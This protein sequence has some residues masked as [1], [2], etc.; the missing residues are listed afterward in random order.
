MKLLGK[1]GSN[2]PISHCN[3]LTFRT[4]IPGTFAPTPVNPTASRLFSND[5]PSMSGERLAEMRE[6]LLLLISNLH[7]PSP[8]VEIHI[9]FVASSNNMSLIVSKP[10]DH[11]L[12]QVTVPL[13]PN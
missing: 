1:P 9:I 8:C 2:S 13:G 11:P 7:N 4:L 10:N 12:F 6:R 3:V 5:K